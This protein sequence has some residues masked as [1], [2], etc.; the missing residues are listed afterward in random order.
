MG[1]SFSNR[2]QTSFQQFPFSARISSSRSSPN[3]GNSS[4]PARIPPKTTRTISDL[5]PNMKWISHSSIF[6]LL[7]LNGCMLSSTLQHT[8]PSQAN[9]ALQLLAANAGS[10]A[11]KGT[12]HPEARLKPATREARHEGSSL[13][14][15]YCRGYPESV[16]YIGIGSVLSDSL[17]EGVGPG[18]SKNSCSEAYHEHRFWEFASDS[19]GVWDFHGTLVAGKALDSSTYDGVANWKLRSGLVLEYVHL[20]YTITS[21]L[22]RSSQRIR[23]DANCIIEFEVFDSLLDSS[24]LRPIS[25][26][27]N[28]GGEQVGWF[29]WDRAELIPRILSLDSEIIA[30]LPTQ[31]VTFPEDSLGLSFHDVRLDTTDTSARLRL[32]PKWRLLARDG[33]RSGDS[34]TLDLL[35][36]SSPMVASFSFPISSVG[37]DSIALPLPRTTIGS[38]TSFQ[39]QLPTTLGIAISAQAPL[40]SP[41]AV[42]P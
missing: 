20:S 40:P 9:S 42:S 6:A 15:Q 33:V 1:P 7:A 37:T 17:S 5:G 30:P 19:T 26:P 34:I 28:C 21:L 29:S 25:A 35:Q 11:A 27:I 32:S 10:L 12:A 16:M 8:S 38:M 39:L 22:F 31:P 14:S 4:Q 24:R 18:G 36:D 23:F 41:T 2:R 13:D 3:E